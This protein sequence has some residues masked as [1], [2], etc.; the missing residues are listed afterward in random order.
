MS[1]R[2]A[3]VAVV[4]TVFL[5]WACSSPE[6]RFEVPWVELPADPA[7]YDPIKSYDYMPIPEDNPLTWEKASLG[8]QLYYDPRLSG[9]GVR[10]CYSCHVCEKGLTDGRPVAIGAFDKV[11]T[12]SAP[13]MWNVGYYERLYWDGRAPSLEAQ[14]KGAWTGGN[15][16]AKDAEAIVVKLNDI[17]DY[18]AQFMNVFGEPATVANVPKALA[19]YMRTLIANNSRFD[20]WQAGETDAIG[21]AAKRGWE[22]FQE[23]GCVECHAGVLFTD[24]QFHNVGIGMSD[25]NP[26]PGRGKVSGL[27][28]DTGAFKTPTLRDVSQ[29]APYFHNGSVPTLEGAVRL[30]AEG[31]LENPW[32]S[33]KLKQD[34]KVTDKQVDDVVAFLQSLDEPCTLTA[35]PLP[36]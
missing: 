5:V 29:S 10:S 20:R 18:R 15:M 7:Q 22:T 2:V 34:N 1:L 21:N 4:A 12:R 36:K 24:Q 6:P 33:D 9:D 11:L 30:M 35:P 26:D 13:T 8:W 3:L 31:G 28:Q 14:A 25:E 16:G 27:E 19:S 32:L 17:P 23:W